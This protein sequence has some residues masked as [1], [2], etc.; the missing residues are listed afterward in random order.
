MMAKKRSRKAPKKSARRTKN[1]A[2]S[3]AAQKDE[4]RRTSKAKRGTSGTGP[5]MTRDEKKP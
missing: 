3:L 5:R 4:V 1:V 2:K